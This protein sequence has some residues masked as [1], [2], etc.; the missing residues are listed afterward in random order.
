MPPPASAP[1]I[2]IARVITRLG[3]GGAALHVALL[4]KHLNGGQFETK[5]L[6]GPTSQIEGDML[7]LRGEDSL[8][9]QIVPSL[10]RDA[11][12]LRD[13]RALRSLVRHFRAFQPDI[14]DTHLSKAGFLGRL[15]ARIVG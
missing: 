2:R 12:P 8:Q 11:T 14:V 13:L 5:L 15:A 4:T 9:L 6:A 7:R 1:P 10:R 3:V